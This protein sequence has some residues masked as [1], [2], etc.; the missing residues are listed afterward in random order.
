[1]SYLLDTNVLSETIKFTPNQSVLN[2][3]Q[4]VPSESLYISVITIGEIRK[5]I[6]KL[7]AGSKKE[8]ILTWLEH[9]LPD[10][11][12]GRI[13]PID[14]DVSDRWGYIIGNSEKTFSSIDSLIAATAMIHNLKLV[15]R[16]VSDFPIPGLEVIN[17]WNFELT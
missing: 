1:M 6:E 17:P 7:E 16:N 4:S 3:F 15:T 12:E 5:G 11:F 10:W 13:L 2:W 8:K 14:F 9:S